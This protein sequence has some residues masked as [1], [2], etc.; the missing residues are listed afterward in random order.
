[1]IAPRRTA[2]FAAS[3]LAAADWM[4]RA[5]QSVA[6]SSAR[7]SRSVQQSRSR[8]SSSSARCCG[9]AWAHAIDQLGS[10]PSAAASLVPI[11][12]SVDTLIAPGLFRPLQ[13]DQPN[14]RKRKRVPVIPKYIQRILS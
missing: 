11:T 7:A 8:S 3:A 10:R 1:M 4:P 5:L 12:L 9:A 14:G 2:D 6:Q 13:S